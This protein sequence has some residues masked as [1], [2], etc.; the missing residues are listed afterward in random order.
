MGNIV[1]DLLRRIAEEGIETWTGAKLSGLA[2]FA[3][4]ELARAGVPTTERSDAAERVLAAVRN[5]LE[6]ER[7]RWI[8]TPHAGAEC[9]WALGGL[10]NR[11]LVSGRIDRTFIDSQ[12]TRWIIDYKTSTHE[13][14][15]RGVFLAEQKRRYESQLGLYARLL[16]DAGDTRVAVGL[17]FP[18]LDEWVSWD[19]PAL[20]GAR[21][22]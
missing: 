5:T 17:Y 19:V 11:Q 4:R 6:S 18:L 10:I 2:A 13:G 22:V 20:V 12:G 3:T 14:G 16:E 8:L 21:P 1:H 9:E 15:G 7:G